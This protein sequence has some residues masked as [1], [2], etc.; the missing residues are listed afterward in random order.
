MWFCNRHKYDFLCST[1]FSIFP[2]MGKTERGEMSIQIYKSCRPPLTYSNPYRLAMTQHLRAGLNAFISV[3]LGS[4]L[5]SVFPEDK[6]NLQERENKLFIWRW[7]LR[8]WWKV[9]KQSSSDF[10]PDVISLADNTALE[11]EKWHVF[12]EVFVAILSPLM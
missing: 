5:E 1:S 6:L 2:E 3:T 7:K 11:L 4:P 12:I 9:W 8:K 10:Y